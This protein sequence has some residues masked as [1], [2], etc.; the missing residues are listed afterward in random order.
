FTRT[1]GGWNH[2]RKRG[3]IHADLCG[4]GLCSHKNR[5]IPGRASCHDGGSAPLD[6][7]SQGC[8]GSDFQAER[9]YHRKHCRAHP[10]PNSKSD[11]NSHTDTN[12]DTNTNTNSYPDP[13][14]KSESF[15]GSDLY[16]GAN[17]ALSEHL[18]SAEWQHCKLAG[19]CGCGHQRFKY[20]FL[21]ADL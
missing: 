13:D 7:A 5:G 6:R 3:F 18:F 14:S 20:S 21:R 10:D 19:A 12:A 1:R 17:I 16:C 9:K 15:T 11:P 8:D 4:W 2:G